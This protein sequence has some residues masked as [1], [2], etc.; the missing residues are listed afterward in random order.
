MQFETYEIVV[1]P[2]VFSRSSL[3]IAF[4]DTEDKNIMC[5]KVWSGG[6]CNVVGQVGGLFAFESTK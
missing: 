1:K 3:E 4:C 5:D 2:I 6:T